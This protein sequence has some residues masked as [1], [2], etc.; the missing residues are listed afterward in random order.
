MTLHEAIKSRGWTVCKT[1][2]LAGVN[3]LT[4]QRIAQ[5]KFYPSLSTAAKLVEVLGVELEFRRVTPGKSEAMR[6]YSPTTQN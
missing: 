1:A 5:S 4:L 3:R 6:C 2:D